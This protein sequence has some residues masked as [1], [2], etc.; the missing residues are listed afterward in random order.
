M[1]IGANWRR[2]N[3]KSPAMLQE[4]HPDAT[5][6]CMSIPRMYLAS[7]CCRTCDVI[8]GIDVSVS[9]LVTTE[10]LSLGTTHRHGHC[11]G[12]AGCRWAEKAVLNTQ[13][14]QQRGTWGRSDSEQT[15]VLS[16]VSHT[17]IPD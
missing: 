4:N 15:A 6:H 1:I 2:E 11:C 10:L 12:C 16:H 3:A 17:D 8:H 13:S 9:K 7:C 5:W 14:N